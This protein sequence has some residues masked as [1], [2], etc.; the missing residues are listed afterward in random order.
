MAAFLYFEKLLH[1]H[2]APDGHVLGDFYGVGTPGRDHGGARS[3]VRAGYAL[4]FYERFVAEEPAEFLEVVGVQSWLQL[5]VELNGEYFEKWV[6]KKEDHGGA[7]FAM[8]G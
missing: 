6:A 2:D 4:R 5:W 8:K 3:D 7:L 1:A